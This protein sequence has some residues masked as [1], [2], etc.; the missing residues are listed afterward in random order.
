M[1]RP[2]YLFNL[3]IVSVLSEQLLQQLAYHISGVIQL[4][5]IQGQMITVLRGRRV[6]PQRP[7]HR[8]SYTVRGVA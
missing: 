7:V 4:H 1:F 3:R 2:P 5:N 8:L 6:L